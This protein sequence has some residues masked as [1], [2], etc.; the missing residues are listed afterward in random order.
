M[1]IVRTYTNISA[2][3]RGASAAVGNFDG[4]HLGHRAV[5]ERARASGQG[6]LGVVTFEPHP[7]SFFAPNAPAFRLMNAEAKENRLARMGVEICYALPFDSA[8]AA[9]SAEEFARDVIAT[10]LGLS[11]VVVGEDFCFGKGRKGT[12]QDLAAF[13]QQ[14]GFG[15]TIA[16]LLSIATE[17]GPVSSTRIR[18]ALAEGRPHD[19]KAMLG[20]W[21]RVEGP[22]VHGE[23]RGRTLGY[24]TAN[25][26]LT[27]LHLPKFGVYA[28]TVDI[29]TGPYTGTYGGVASLGVRPM[30]GE[31]QPNLETHIFDFSGDLY[32]AH[33]SVG[34]VDYLRAEQRFDG[35]D[36][37][38]AQMSKDSARARACLAVT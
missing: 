37:L 32:G 27:G 34:L 8:L 23:K 19:A 12:A 31:N 7:R 38:I 26:M 21:H 30:F 14:M 15:V 2:E 36:G 5:I 22:V 33:L 20:H 35:V 16:P 10:G 29:R 11:H 17:A 6:P 4:V 18:A 3:D 13:G 9:L 1:R 25:M 28:V 24:P